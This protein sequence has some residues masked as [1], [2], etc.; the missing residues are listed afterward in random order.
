[1]DQSVVHQKEFFT[2]SVN[3]YDLPGQAFVVYL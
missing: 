1:M 2:E 3:M